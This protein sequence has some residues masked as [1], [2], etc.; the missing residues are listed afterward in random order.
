MDLK[1]LSLWEERQYSPSGDNLTVL[2]GSRFR[3]CRICERLLTRVA[4]HGA[5]GKASTCIEGYLLQI[6]GFGSSW[7]AF[8]CLL[9]DDATYR[10][11]DRL[12]ENADDQQHGSESRK[13]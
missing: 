8:G 6:N 10:K 5:K 12:I 1:N 3:D 7:L 2:N 13:A 4:S 9:N 11:R